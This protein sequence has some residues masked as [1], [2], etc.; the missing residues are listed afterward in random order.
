MSTKA[1]IGKGAQYFLAAT[2]IDGFLMCDWGGRA[3]D[4][5]EAT[6]HDSPNGFAEHI[7]GVAEA[8]SWDL[9]FHWNPA[10]ASQQLLEDD[11]DSGTVRSHKVVV[12]AKSYTCDGFVTGIRTGTPIRDKL[13][14]VVTVK[15]TGKP[16]KAAA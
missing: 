3:R 11:L 6:E 16:V 4:S 13:T 12:G 14:K 2:Q 10:N 15:L 8:G 1:I 7:P 9:T 5:I